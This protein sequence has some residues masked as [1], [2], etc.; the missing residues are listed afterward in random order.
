MRLKH[1]QGIFD[2]LD[3]FCLL[4]KLCNRRVP[5]VFIE[6]L[7]C[8]FSKCYVSVRWCD[9]FS[10]PIQTLAGVR[11]GGILSP[12]LF[13]LYIDPLITKLKDC[14]FGTHIY[15]VFI[16]CIIYADDILLIAN[17]INHM[18]TML[19]I[20]TEMIT[21]LGLHFNV[22]KSTVMRIGPRFDT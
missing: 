11:Q 5:R 13:A 19:N 2:K 9:H 3:Q 8:W 22:S 12:F 21:A 6:I 14:G 18:Q 17:S 16:G 10:K 20:C 15:N 4:N 7:L 1:I